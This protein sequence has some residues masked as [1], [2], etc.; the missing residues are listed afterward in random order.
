[1]SM[2]ACILPAQHRDVDEHEGVDKGVERQHGDVVGAHE[3][4]PHRTRRHVGPHKPVRLEVE[5]EAQ[6]QE[7][8]ELAVYMYI[9]IYIYM[10]VC[11]CIYIYIYIYH[12][13]QDCQSQP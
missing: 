11:V 10:C 6:V 1:M 12:P 13:P 2:Y 3:A 8:V 4:Q 9:S 5:S 7:G